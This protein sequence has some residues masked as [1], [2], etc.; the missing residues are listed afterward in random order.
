LPNS[1][2]ELHSKVET[3]MAK[4]AALPGRIISYFKHRFIAYA[5]AP[6]PVPA[7]G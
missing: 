4:L 7:S 3:F 6:D 2:E 5:A 1:R